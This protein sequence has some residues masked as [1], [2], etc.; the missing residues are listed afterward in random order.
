MQHLIR[1]SSEDF[2]VLTDEANLKKCALLNIYALHSFC[3]AFMPI[4]RQSNLIKILF[5]YLL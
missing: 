3:K 1:Y 5:D 2:S 4:T